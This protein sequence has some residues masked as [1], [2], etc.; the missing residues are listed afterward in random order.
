MFR[1]IQIVIISNFVVSSVGIRR[2]DCTSNKTYV[3]D[4]PEQNICSRYTRTKIIPTLIA[5]RP[6]K[7]HI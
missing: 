7:L 5:G 6:G 4:T 2:V 3:P 1:D